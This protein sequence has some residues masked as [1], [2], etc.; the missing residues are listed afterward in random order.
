MK[1]FQSEEDYTAASNGR[2]VYNCKEGALL[3][4]GGSFSDEKGYVE[5]MDPKNPALLKAKK[6]IE[7]VL[8]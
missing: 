8:N 3:W 2:H 7:E 1:R 4:L 5:V 6:I